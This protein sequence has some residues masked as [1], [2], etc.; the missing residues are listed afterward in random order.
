M[1]IRIQLVN[2]Q[3]LI[4]EGLSCLLE[5]DPEVIILPS[6]QCGSGCGQACMQ[7]GCDIIV[8]GTNIGASGSI[9]CL[10]QI[11]SRNAEARVLL[12]ICKEQASLTREAIRVG[13]KGVLSMEAPSPILRKAVRMIARGGTFIEPWLA[14]SVAETPY[15]HVNN[16]FDALTA[17]ELS[18]LHMILAGC[19]GTFIANEL[20][21]S[22]KTVANH[23]T[24]LMNKLAVNN[25][26]ELT[27]MAIRHDMIKA[28]D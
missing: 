23:H 4:R 27:R 1:T 16:P 7:S 17:R 2:E 18:V 10:R 19:G 25:L 6:V 3:N 21:I 11:V 28:N 26:V 5:I 12:M 9:N 22:T 13:A 14:S 8:V 24:H 15:G 20:H